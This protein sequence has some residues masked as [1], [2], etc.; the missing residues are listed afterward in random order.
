MKPKPAGVSGPK[1]RPVKLRPYL[2]D[3]QPT[4]HDVR[5]TYGTS[6]A[7]QGVKIHDLMELV[8]HKDIRSA[9]RYLHSQEGRFD[10]AREARKRA[11]GESA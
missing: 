5:H 10:R 3:P 7:D 4:F 9:Q 8:G 11:R 1:R 2:D 6:L